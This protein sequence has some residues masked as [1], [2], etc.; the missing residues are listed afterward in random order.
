MK[1]EIK[2]DNQIPINAYLWSPKPY[3][4]PLHFHSSLEIG[5]CFSGKGKF[6]FEN[7]N[8]DVS[9]GDI[10]IVNNTELHIAQSAEREP[11]Q[12]IFLNFEP[13]IFLEADEKLLLPFAYRSERF[14]N[15]I[16]A[17]TSLAVELGALIQQIY[18]E[19]N[20]KAEAYI[21]VTRCKLLELGVLLL[22]HYMN[23]FSNVQW[24]KM[25]HSQR[26]IKELMMFAK[27]RFQEPIQ[28]NDAAVHLGWSVARTSKLFKEHTGTSFLNY[29]M[30]L[31]ISE[32][33]KQLVTNQDS[34]ADICF[35]SG[36]QSLASFY[37]T[38]GLA[39]GMSPQEY[40]K[41]FG[42]RQLF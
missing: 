17:G 23:A 7:K 37:R 16:A 29:I 9:K 5:Y 11:S 12:Y 21:I 6:I 24:L 26:E 25:T 36:F 22:R 38:F 3:Q 13:S 31:R 15:H 30:Q 33:K 10:F 34:I 14:E 4:Q 20:N 41:Q 19:L 40:R 39:A 32:A 8:Y 1:Q 27:E 42:I 35:S 18:E 2:Y 28:L